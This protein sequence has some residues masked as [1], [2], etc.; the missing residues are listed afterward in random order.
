MTVTEG[1]RDRFFRRFVEEGAE[2][3]VR[4]TSAALK[5]AFVSDAVDSVDD[6]SVGGSEVGGEGSCLELSETS[7]AGKVSTELDAVVDSGLL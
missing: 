5:G 1:A 6:E 2:G 3:G 7:S 4:D